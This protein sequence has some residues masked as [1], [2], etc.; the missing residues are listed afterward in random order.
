MVPFFQRNMIL[1]LIIM[2]IVPGCV[3]ATKKDFV[4]PPVRSPYKGDYKVV[5]IAYMS[6]GSVEA[7]VAMNLRGG[8]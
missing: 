6:D 4:P 2:L 3:V 7:T 1:G 8:C 5:D